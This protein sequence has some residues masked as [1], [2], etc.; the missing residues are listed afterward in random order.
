MQLFNFLV[1]LGEASFGIAKWRHPDAV[2][3]FVAVKDATKERF[4]VKSK[5][6]APAKPYRS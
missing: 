3:A 2:K 4:C 6:Q 1:D 5:A